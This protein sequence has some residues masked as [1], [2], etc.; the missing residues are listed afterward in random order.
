MPLQDLGSETVLNGI[1]NNGT[2]VRIVGLDS[3]LGSNPGDPPDYVSSTENITWNNP[4]DA[5]GTWQLVT[6]ASNPV[7]WVV[8]PPINETITITD[9]Q[10]LDNS[11]LV[12]VRAPVNE[13]FERDGEFTLDQLIVAVE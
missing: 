4:S 6:S 2:K 5:S 12:V 10:I 9:V 11:N 7:T 8:E 1:R 3:S 13:V